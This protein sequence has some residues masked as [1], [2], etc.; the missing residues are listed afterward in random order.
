MQLKTFRFFFSSES[1]RKRAMNTDKFEAF[2]SNFIPIEIRI[3]ERK[4]YFESRH[5]SIMMMRLKCSFVLP[6]WSWHHHLIPVKY[7]EQSSIEIDN[8]IWKL[9][10]FVK[11]NRFDEDE[12]INL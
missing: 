8:A 9:K 4:I 6:N 5:S 3:F 12:F 7:V 2:L 1:K 10:L 11:K